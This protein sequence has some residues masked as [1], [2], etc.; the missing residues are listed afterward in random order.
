M[1]PF[2]LRLLTRSFSLATGI[3]LLRYCRV[4]DT[5]WVGEQYRQRGKKILNA[6]GVTATVNMRIEFDDAAHGLTLAYHCHLPTVDDTPPTL[7]ALRKGVAFIAAMHREGRRVYI[8]CAGGLGRAPT[9]ACAYL[10]SKGHTPEEALALIKRTRPF[11]RLQ[12][13]QAKQ[14]QAFYAGLSPNPVLA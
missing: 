6:A 4:T 8:H 2:L 5:L 9:M 14:L 13:S 1:P 12:P 10:I 7:E 3:P 11:A